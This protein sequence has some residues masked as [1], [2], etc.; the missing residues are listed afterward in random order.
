VAQKQKTVENA[1]V[2]ASIA[3]PSTPEDRALVRFSSD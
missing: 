2:N 1:T 3:Q